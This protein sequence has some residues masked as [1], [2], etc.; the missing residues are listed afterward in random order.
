MK[1]YQR[2][3]FL[4]LFPLALAWQYVK[5]AGKFAES[6]A[7]PAIAMLIA[8]VMSFGLLPQGTLAAAVDE[9][10]D[11]GI[12]F[13]YENSG[14]LNITMPTT[15]GYYT[16]GTVTFGAAEKAAN[17][18]DLPESSSDWHWAVQKE[19]DGYRMIL[20]IFNTRYSGDTDGIIFKCDLTLELIGT[21][22][23]YTYREAEGTALLRGGN[24]A[25]LTIEGTG[26]F[27]GEG[28]HTGISVPGALNIKGG[29]Q[30]KIS[31]TNRA[32][33]AGS[34]ELDA[35]IYAL[36]SD[37]E[38]GK[39]AQ[40]YN[41]ANL[42]NT[43]WFNSAII[44]PDSSYNV[45]FIPE[46][47]YTESTVGTM[48]DVRTSGEYVIPE[49]SFTNP[50]GMIF[51]HWVTNGETRAPGEKILVSANTYIYAYWEDD[52]NTFIVYFNSNRGSGYTP[53][54]AGVAGDYVLPN[55]QYTAPAGMK[56]KAWRINDVE[57]AEGDTVNVTANITV[58]AVWEDDPSTIAVYFDGNGANGYVAPVLNN[59]NGEF[60]YTL[61]ENTYSVP[62]NRYFAGWLVGE[63]LKQPGETITVTEDITVKPCWKAKDY[64]VTV[65][66]V[67]INYQNADNVTG[68]N[69]EGTVTYD[70]ETQTLTLN[71]AD[72]SAVC[73]DDRWVEAISTEYGFEGTL[74]ICLVGEN[75]ISSIIPE[76]VVV[77][78]RNYTIY[79][80]A[81]AFTG[82]GS[83]TITAGEADGGWSYAINCENVTFG[84]ECT[85]IT[86]SLASEGNFRS[87][88][89]ADSLVADD[90]TVLM[91]RSSTGEPLEAYTESNSYRSTYIIVQPK[92][93]IT[94][95]FAANGAS[96]TMADESAVCA[97][98]YTL[99]ECGFTAPSGKKFKA[100]SVNG[101]EKAVGDKVI[102]I[103][104]TTITAIWEDHICDFGTEWE[105]DDNNHWK[106]CACGEKQGL[107]AHND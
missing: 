98:E 96:G 59:T 48:A 50:A 83:L 13:Y 53:S 62:S 99:P 17:V 20:N 91:S 7:R 72:I 78:S 55:N 35:N 69:I 85:V 54:S 56:F 22:R 32:I 37:N 51:D 43:K 106:Q 104:N 24:S 47:A 44:E 81:L 26:S 64:Y 30:I 10:P 57:Y 87:G 67:A 93:N 49:S 61:P 12:G 66:G 95:S 3:L 58:F 40:T 88:I 70:Y 11:G 6:K 2:V 38:S 25:N 5:Q 63:E 4:V 14:F 41:F 18:S 65:G 60:R 79:L 27:N 33:E 39:N 80:D 97:K 8:A 76:G 90:S 77:P 9:V 73:G 1:S 15:E 52:P 68:E 21:N 31:S 71:N 94:V 28:T 16:Y 89:Y 82:D 84:G 75:T 29:N 107:E 101:K 34:L 92:Y 42:T 102:F 36:T 86:K 19:T 103:E 105:A 74:T 100:W 46:S 23:Y 45:R